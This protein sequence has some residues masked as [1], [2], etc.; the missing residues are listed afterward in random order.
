MECNLHPWPVHVNPYLMKAYFKSGSNL[1]V[2]AMLCFC[3]QAKGDD[4]IVSK[5]EISEVKVYSSGATIT[6][7]AKVSI[8]A[9]QSQIK[10]ENLSAAIQPSSILVSATG[11][12]TILSVTHQMDYLGPDRKTPEMLKLEDSL[13]ALN[14]KRD[15]M[16]NQI[17]VLQEEQNVLLAN[18]SI[19]GA[20]TGVK[21]E[22]LKSISTYVRNRLLEIKNAVLD[23]SISEKKLKIEIDKLNNQLAIL[24]N[25]RNEPYSSILVNVSASARTTGNFTI[26]YYT[27][28]VSWQPAYDIRVKDI[29]SP[30]E[31]VY[32]AM[33]TQNTGEDWNRV[34]M[35][36][37]TGNPSLGATAPELYPWY[38]NFMQYE[39]MQVQSSA[40]EGRKEKEQSAK[41]NVMMPGA[42][43]TMDS[44][45]IPSQNRFNTEYEIT[46]PYSVPSNNL[47]YAVEI[48]NYKLN[49]TYSYFAV[50]KIENDAFLVASVSGWEELD[51][52]PGN[53]NIY[54]ENTFVGESSFNPVT[55]D[56]T[57]KISLGRDKHTVI[58]RE[59]IKD[60]TG[61]QLIGQNR[62]RNFAFDITVKNTHKETIKLVLEDQ[63]PISSDKEIEVKL[64]EA[65]GGEF[66]PET[67]KITWKLEIPSGQQVKKKLSF[68]VKYPK[69]KQVS[70][71]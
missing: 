63:L 67:G 69:D 33:V 30:V 35:R 64:I 50:P 43:T 58:K 36:I 6:R 38:L 7:N 71:L 40:P 1:L 32:K 8:E 49:A 39:L 68:S 46:I 31:L 70:G 5:T 22:E 65:S 3:I 56:D 11:E 15:G 53:S 57:L 12:F 60:V 21:I 2:A 48:R 37:S 42:A 28:N 47:N 19:G 24:N 52:Q 25:K 66:N 29:S 59:K 14:R 13:Q 44:Y 10:F 4:R 54:Y 41:P 26:S 18:K 27:G 9:G 17:A 55:A 45:V 34:K 61:N 23:L 16:L 51:L 20:N 62:V